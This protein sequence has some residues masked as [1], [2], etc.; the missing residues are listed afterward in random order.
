MIAEKNIELIKFNDILTHNSLEEL[1]KRVKDVC[2]SEGDGRAK[3]RRVY[4][5]AVELLDN[6]Y[7]HTEIYRFSD[8]AIDFKLFSYNDKYIIEVT[9]II[10]N[11]NIPKLQER[12]D[13]LK[14]K[15]K[16]ELKE[17][18]KIKII[19]SKISDKGGAGIGLIDIAR[20]SEN[21]IRYNFNRINRFKSY[22]TL[23]IEIN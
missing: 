6:S 1:L 15:S 11:R 22:F 20:K 2:S 13:L 19:N 9:N 3:S 10:A 18:Y 7:M 16:A 12:L 21:T 4:S 8:L 14:N 23:T 5:V 17:L